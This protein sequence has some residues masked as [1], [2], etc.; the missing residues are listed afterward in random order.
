MHNAVRSAI[1]RRYLENELL[2]Y[3]QIKTRIAKLSGITPIIHDMGINSCLGY[4]GPFAGLDMS[5][6]R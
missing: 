2:S 4:M 5:P 1:V 3:A 6:K